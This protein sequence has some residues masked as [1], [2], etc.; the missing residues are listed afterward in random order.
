MKVTQRIGRALLVSVTFGALVL[1]ATT[2]TAPSAE[3]GLPH[4]PLC[5][6]TVLWKCS[7]PGSSSVRFAGTVCLRA[8]FERKTGLTCTPLGG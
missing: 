8:R 4:G 5:G 2:L 7:K 1:G 6:P 3:A